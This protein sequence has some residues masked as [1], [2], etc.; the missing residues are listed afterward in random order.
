M[1]EIPDFAF[2][3]SLV[4]DP[5]RALMLTALLDGRALPAGELAYA[6]RIAPQTASS[7]LAKLL[8]GGLLAVETEGRHRYYRLAGGHVAEALERLSV[9]APDQPVRRKAISGKARELR[10]CRCCYDHLAGQVGVAVTQGLVEHGYLVPAADKQFRVTASGH[11]WFNS[12]G[13]DVAALK[14][15]A[16][17]LARQCLDWTERS[18]HLAGPL[19]VHL[20][21][22]M[23]K[24][25][26][27]RRSK[28]SRAVQVTPKGW[29]E[30]RRQLGIDPVSTLAA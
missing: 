5:A 1:P 19:G 7:H 25:G 3:A 6:A 20:L 22:T 21:S 2:A 16:R 13:L 29:I 15:T 26:W 18:H 9:L 11:A 28:D 24:L 12:I 4:A 8:A 14:P 23:C 27:L 17:G 30:L 10:Y